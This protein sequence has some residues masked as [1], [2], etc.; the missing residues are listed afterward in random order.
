[1][2]TYQQGKKMS[3]PEIIEEALHLKPQERYLIIENL[4]KSLDE[5]NQEIDELWIEESKKR[6]QAYRE[7]SAKTLSYEQV[8]KT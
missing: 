7:G 6:L 8:F 2:K 1:M 4:V 3:L 5:P